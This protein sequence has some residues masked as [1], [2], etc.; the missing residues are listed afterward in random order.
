MGRQFRGIAGMCQSQVTRREHPGFTKNAYESA[1]IETNNP[2]QKWAE[3][4][5]RHFSRENILIAPRTR[6]DAEV[7]RSLGKSKSKPQ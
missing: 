2:I 1:A 6:K 7:H 5:S 4:S 3:D